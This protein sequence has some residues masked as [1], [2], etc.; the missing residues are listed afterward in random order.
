MSSKNSSLQV[1]FQIQLGRLWGL[2]HLKAW[3]ISRF[4][5]VCWENW[6]RK[7]PSWSS[8]MGISSIGFL[9]MMQVK[10]IYSDQWWLVTSVLLYVT[11]FFCKNRLW[12]WIWIIRIQTQPR[13]LSTIIP[14]KNNHQTSMMLKK[15]NACSFTAIPVSPSPKPFGWQKP[16][17]F[18]WFLQ[19]LCAPASL[20]R[21]KSLEDSGK[22]GWK[23]IEKSWE[24]VENHGGKSTMR[25]LGSTM[26]AMDGRGLPGLE[27]N[28]TKGWSWVYVFS[29]NPVLE[30]HGQ[31]D[32][33]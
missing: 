31:W 27:K 2:N 19:V 4:G 14:I 22:K 3:E 15:G 9:W 11:M 21:T 6:K 17:L 18:P 10:S 26:A 29:R 24:K 12:I 8:C 28:T 7:S 1:T 33:W 5:W 23:S 20:L 32:F 30:Q 25:F 13:I 16:I